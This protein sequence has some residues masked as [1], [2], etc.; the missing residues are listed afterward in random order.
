M[1]VTGSDG[2]GADPGVRNLQPPNKKPA[3]KRVFQFVRQTRP[4]QSLPKRPL[5][6][7]SM[8]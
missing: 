2:Q 3:V 1:R 5:A 7:A 8:V 4:A 6:W